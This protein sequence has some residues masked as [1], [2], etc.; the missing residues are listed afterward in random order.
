VADGPTLAKKLG[1]LFRH[2]GE[3][4]RRGE[5]GRERIAAETGAL[6]RTLGLLEPY[7][8]QAERPAP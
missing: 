6:A 5:A 8:V 1:E 7:L 3:R 4:K 2:P